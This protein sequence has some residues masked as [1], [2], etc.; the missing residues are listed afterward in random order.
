MNEQIIVAYPNPVNDVI[1]FQSALKDR[2]FIYIYD[3]LGSLVQCLDLDDRKKGL[4]VEAYSE[5]IYFYRGLA[6]NGANLLNGRFVVS[7]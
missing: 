2:M 5:G 7:R 1:Y 6:D 3:G 4:N